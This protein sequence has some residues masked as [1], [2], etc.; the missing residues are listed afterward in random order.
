MPNKQTD[1]LNKKIVAFHKNV[2]RRMDS[3]SGG[4][5]FALLESF[6]KEEGYYCVPEHDDK[7]HLKYILTNDPNRIVDV[8]DEC[9]TEIHME[10]EKQLI[11]QLLKAGKRVLFAG[12][13]CHCV[14]LREYLGKDFSTLFIVGIHCQGVSEDA[15]IDKYI[16]ELED[17]YNDKIT[18]I[19]FHDKEF[20]YYDSKRFRLAGGKTVYLYEKEPFDS[21]LRQGVFLKERCRKC[22]AMDWSQTIGDLSI[23]NGDSTYKLG[24]HLG[25]STMMIH[26][27]KGRSLFEMARKRLEICEGMAEEPD[28]HFYGKS[29]LLKSSSVDDLDCYTL[30]ECYNR[31]LAKTNSLLGTVKQFVRLCSQIQKT[32]RLHPVPLYK[33]IKYNFLRKN[34]F[35]NFK[36]LGYIFVAPYSEFNLAKDAV[37]ELHGPLYV[38]TAK[39][40]PTS[41]LETRLWMREK[42]KLVVHRGCVFAFGGD[43][44]IFKGAVLDVGDL[45]TAN[46]FTII[47]GERIEIGYPVNIAKNTEVR[48]TNSHLLSTNGYKLNR[49]VVI[50]NHVWIASNCFIMPG[51][52]I[53][54]GCVVAGASYV[55]KKVPCFSIVEGH[56]AEVKSSV[57]YF[58]M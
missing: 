3:A 41:R 38:G 12:H 57:K 39:R 28:E 53:G 29:S 10:D 4:V 9:M 52:K 5:L 32:T 45:I 6:M 46:P 23:S 16:K 24:D 27:E 49:P 43:V 34:T 40:V 20:P 8:V 51:A 19:H 7:F 33:F 31:T 18:D 42:S 25:Y 56:P 22:P 11:R 36:H 14:E 15:L 55:N 30:E 2:E 37:L 26:S 50:G 35:T 17:K 47:C 48:D 21:L 44:E 54:D 13:P 1:T 58:R